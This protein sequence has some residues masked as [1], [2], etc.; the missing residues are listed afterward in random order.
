MFKIFDRNHKQIDILENPY[1]AIITDELNGIG[2]LKFT[3]PITYKKLQLEGYVQVKDGHE[4]VIKEITTEG[5]ERNVHCVLNIEELLGMVHTT[6][7][8]KENNLNDTMKIILNGT[9]WTHVNNSTRT[10]TRNLYGTVVSSY[11]MLQLMSTVFDVEFYFDTHKK[12]VYIVDRVGEDNG[13]YFINDLNLKQLSQD[14]HTHNLI[15][16][17]I[18][19]GKDNLNI[20]EVNGGKMWL[21]NHTYSNKIIYGVWQV[22]DYDNATKLKEDAQRYLNEMAIPYES[23][24]IQ[25]TDISKLANNP[26]FKYELGDVITIIDNITETRIKQRI[27]RKV[28]NLQDPDADII[29]I[30]SKDKSFED[31]YKRM[32]TVADMTDK[33]INTDGTINSEAIDKVPAD[34]IVGDI[35]ATS[36]KADSIT[37]DH[38]KAEQIQSKHIS[39]DAVSANHIK[40]NSIQTNHLQANSVTSKHIQ[41]DTITSAHI[42][43]GAIT[44]GS[45]I[46][47]D[48][49]IGNAQISNLDAS[50][51]T[52]GTIDTSDITIAGANQNLR[53]T[54]NRLQVFEGVGSKQKERVS[55]GD[56]N[57]DGSVYG[58]R[59]RG[60]DGTTVLFDDNGVTKE[61]ITDGSITNDKINPNA[62]IDASK[63][64]I[65]SV[66]NRINKDGSTNIQGNRISIDNKSLSSVISE[67]NTKNTA[68]D[69]TIASQASSITANTNAIKLKVD[70]QTYTTDKNNMTSKLD[71]ATSDIT[72]MKGQI[73]LKVEQS[74]INN[75]VNSLNNTIDSKINNAKSEIKATTDSITNRVSKTE[76]NVTNVTNKVNNLQVGGV[77]LFRNTQSF[78]GDCWKGNSTT[79]YKDGDIPYRKIFSSSSSSWIS[80][81]GQ[82]LPIQANTEY[83]MSALVRK[84]TDEDVTIAWRFDATNTTN[85]T[86]KVT[87]KEWHRVVFPVSSVSKNVDSEPVFLFVPTNSTCVSTTTSVDIAYIKFERGNKATDYTVAPED[88]ESKVTGLTTRVETA[89][90]KLTKNSLT[91]TIGNYYTTPSDVNNSIT[92]KGY[93]TSSQVQQTV[94]KLAI[95]FRQS[96]GY[97]MLRNSDFK[98]GM[99]NWSSLRWDTQAGGNH[100][101]NIWFCGH[102][103]AMENRNVI[104]SYVL[105]IP[106]SSANLPLRAGF[107]SSKFGVQGGQVYTFSCYL[108]GHR[109]E[110][111]MIEMLCYDASGNRIDGNNAT[112]TGV[113]WGGRDRKNWTKIN[114]HFTTQS[115]A[116]SCHVRVFMNEW[117]GGE[118]TAYLWMAEPV[119]CQGGNP[120]EWSPNPEELTAGITSIDSDGITVSMSNGEGNQGYS[121]IDYEGLSIYNANGTRKAW[122]GDDDT[123]Y[124]ANLSADTITNRHLIKWAENAPSTI[125]V[126]PTATG[127]GTGRNSSN[128]ANSVTGALEWYRR[129]YGNYIYKRDITVDIAG[130]TYNEHIYVGGF[131]GSGM[132]NISFSANAIL[133]GSITVEENTLFTKLSGNGN[134]WNGSTGAIIESRRNETIVVRNCNCLITG[135]RS[136]PAQYPNY[137]SNFV[138]PQAGARVW[139]QDCDLVKYWSMATSNGCGHFHSIDNAGDIYYGLNQFWSSWAYF[140][141]VYTPMT[142]GNFLND[143]WNS[144]IYCVPNPRNS[145]WI[146][147]DTTPPVVTPTYKWFENTFSLTNLRTVPEGS[148]SG[149]SSRSGE[150]GQGKWGSYKPHRGYA[151]VSGVSSWCSGGRNFSAYMTLTRSSSGHGYAG[152]VPV[153]KIKRPDGSFWSCGVA[154]A[155]GATH[156]FQLPSEIANALA[157]GSMTTLEMWAGTSTNDYS[158]YNSGS[159]KIKC[160]KQ[161]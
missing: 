11:H 62:N 107:D 161:V 79:V 97:N 15:T 7:T 36:I 64:N 117:I 95:S 28:Y 131:L 104:C 127:D 115:N 152:A 90:S 14:T 17:V 29:N 44:A 137:G 6:F 85:K 34:K 33:V 158:F 49:A 91:T 35:L 99:A 144:D 72:T 5:R 124:I 106:K 10:Y 102:E 69:S 96:G 78:V 67:I 94:D 2:E 112:C 52:A 110:S 136:R 68:Q 23:Y 47:A 135:F 43:T 142:V 60:K 134:P 1:N 109:I 111:V 120:V 56:V 108:A 153:P 130:G 13:T 3:V 87:S 159:I 37:A 20:S 31:Y 66:I 101:T 129:T 40:A 16:R 18:P 55:L 148:G 50:K 80:Y 51:L 100:D 92:S 118:Q 83:I 98:R 89:E 156:T 133:Y 147:K 160:E 114:H 155:R 73:A 116:V 149:T 86:V 128:K 53:I 24:E 141:S 59:V 77:N 154:F 82:R 84:N 45:G 38:I 126:A 138:Q 42:Q 103:W 65:N 8:S 123:A 30:A 41:A 74:H 76:T 57:A 119:V 12:I 32:Q 25:V 71:K 157:N 4:Y 146:P 9:K 22:T 121:K 93:Q 21:E 46:I 19:L 132:I 48:G 61:G 39:A 151:N 26:D 58:I 145:A 81:T 143:T 27:Y 140:S 88:V 122:F 63:I 54:G 70:T 75:A 139:V 150:W 113:S 125:Y 105:N